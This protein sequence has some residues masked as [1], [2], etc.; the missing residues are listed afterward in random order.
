MDMNTGSDHLSETFIVNNR[1]HL[2]LK[3]IDR[4]HYNRDEAYAAIVNSKSRFLHYS[5]LEAV[6]RYAFDERPMG[7]IWKWRR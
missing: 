4:L 3:E 1:Q 7:R 6:I 2:F 5:E